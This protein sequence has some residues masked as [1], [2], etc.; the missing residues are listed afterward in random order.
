MN[1]P[2]PLNLPSV[3][4]TV[5]YRTIDGVRKWVACGEASAM[6][7]INWAMPSSPLSTAELNALYD[8]GAHAANGGRTV[9][10]LAAAIAERYGYAPGRVGSWAAALAALRSGAVLQMSGNY[11]D[12]PIHLQ[13]FDP[14]FGRNPEAWHG[15][16]VGPIADG[17]TSADPW[18]W[19]RDP[20]QPGGF[21]GEWIA[22]TTAVTFGLGPAYV[23]VF[24]RNAWTPAPAPVPAPP[25][26]PTP[27]PE[28]LPTPAP[29]QPEHVL[30]AIGPQSN[31]LTIDRLP[32]IGGQGVVNAAYGAVMAGE[33]WVIDSGPYAGGYVQVDDPNW[34]VDGVAPAP[35]PAP[36]P[37]PAP[38]PAPEPSPAPTPAPAPPPPAP[39]T[40][41]VVRGDTLGRIG[42][43]FNVAWRD[44]YA[45]NVGVIGAD[46]N[47][48]RPGQ[49]LVIPGHFV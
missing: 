37:S 42:A 29:G 31:V 1:Q 36:A 19:W 26:T 5:L 47:L 46:P 30:G 32:W 39:L 7:G 12:L 4:E 9:D 33:W 25:P 41:T 21:N 28:P 2:A 17:D 40:Y 18:V 13:R 38:T 10:Q 15:V 27:Q 24:G 23:L 3:T 45:A 8:T 34:S 44:I 22:W 35:A 6:D 14:A 48:I 43:R 20:L 16:A 49:V 11:H